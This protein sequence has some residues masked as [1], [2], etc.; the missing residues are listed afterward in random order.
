MSK[1]I[2]KPKSSLTSVRLSQRS[3]ELLQD[4]EEFSQQMEEEGCPPTSAAHLRKLI[5]IAL[6]KTVA[7]SE[8][9][10]FLIR[11]IE[12][13]FVKLRPKRFLSGPRPGS[14]AALDEIEQYA[15]Q[16]PDSAERT[17]VL[18]RVKQLRECLLGGV[19]DE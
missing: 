16:L 12:R 9:R 14:A 11:G 18:R 7:K 2:T 13:G 19:G 3:G 15:S 10:D 5:R 17:S 1:N 4:M 6:E 8:R